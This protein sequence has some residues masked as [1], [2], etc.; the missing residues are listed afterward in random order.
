[1]ISPLLPTCSRRHGAMNAGEP[2]AVLECSHRTYDDPATEEPAIV[3]LAAFGIA[4][5]CR[6]CGEQLQIT[7]PDVPEGDKFCRVALTAPEVQVALLTLSPALPLSAAP[8]VSSENQCRRCSAPLMVLNDPRW[9]EC[10]LTYRSYSLEAEGKTEHVFDSYAVSCLCGECR[11]E[12]PFS[13]PEAMDEE[14]HTLAYLWTAVA[15]Q[16]LSAGETS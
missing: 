1:M 14:G 5:L 4:T 7:S 11:K 15:I 6:D 2:Y 3:T 10:T 8:I 12:L 13:M 9:M 16:L